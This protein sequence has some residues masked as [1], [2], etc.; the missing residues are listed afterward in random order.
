MQKAGTQNQEELSL[1][2]TQISRASEQYQVCE[3]WRWQAEESLRA[4]ESEL[5]QVRAECR[6]YKQRLFSVEL[7]ARIRETNHQMQLDDL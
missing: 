3:L 4:A 6:T 2:Q 5:G 7:D 1:L